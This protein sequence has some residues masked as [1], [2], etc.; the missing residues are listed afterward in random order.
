M[1]AMQGYRDDEPLTRRE[2]AA[3]AA[4]ALGVPTHP[5]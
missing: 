4:R 2:F 1:K 5:S 3:A